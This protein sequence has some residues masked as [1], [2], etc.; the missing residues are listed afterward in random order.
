MLLLVV[1]DVGN[2]LAS[3]RSFVLLTDE[4]L[5]YIVEPRAGII[6]FEGGQETTFGN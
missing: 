5:A 1:N 6:L 4:L 3:W 2:L